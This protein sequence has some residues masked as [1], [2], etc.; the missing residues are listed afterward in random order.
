MASHPLDRSSSTGSR[1]SNSSYPW[2]CSY[3]T[4]QNKNKMKQDKKYMVMVALI[5]ALGG[6]VWGFDATVISGAVPFIQKYFNLAGDRGDFLLG[7]AVSCLGWGVLG[8][9]AVAGFFSDRFGRKKVLITTAVFFAGRPC[10]LRSPQTLTCSPSPE[11][12]AAWQWVVPFSS[13]RS[14]S[15]KSRRRNDAAVLYR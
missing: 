8:G 9:T 6:F 1:C 14:I 15:Q 7:L 2:R 13:R 11:L 5:V 4:Q 10:F 12:S 3:K